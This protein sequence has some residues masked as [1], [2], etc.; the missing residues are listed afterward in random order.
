MRLLKRLRSRSGETFTELLCAVLVTAIAM[1]LLFGMVSGASRLNSR[2]MA[3]DE[4]LYSAL[5]AAERGEG[6]PV[7]T[8]SGVTVTVTGESG[9]KTIQFPVVFSGETGL[10]LSYAAEESGAEG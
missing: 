10:L 4:A 7:D 2:A 8:D 1:S 5:S 9:E 3:A 6:E